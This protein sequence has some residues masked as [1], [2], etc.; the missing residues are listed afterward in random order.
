MESLRL[1][2]KTAIVTGAGRGLGRAHALLLASRGAAVVV[3]DVGV[4]V[5]GTGQAAGPAES[6]V[7]EILAAGG[8]AVAD[9]HSVSEPDAG[10]TL[11]ELARSSFGSVDIIVNNAGIARP[12]PVQHIN[13]ADVIEEMEVHLIGPMS[14]LAAAWSDLKD[15]GTGRV[16]NTASGVGAFGL[17]GAAGYAAAKAA[18]MGFTRTAALE[19]A[20]HGIAVNGVAPIAQTR[21]AGATF[22]DLSAH[23]DPDLVASVVLWLCHPTCPANG[24]TFSAGGGRVARIIVA[25][26]RGIHV[27]GLSAEDVAA[28]APALLADLAAIE[29][30]D[31]MTETELIRAGVE[32]Q[33][34][35]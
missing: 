13:P 23:L 16:V 27:K 25:P 5:A 11:V 30:A 31:A 14:L 34:T 1:D 28:A 10:A 6:V 35:A 22:G 4:S 9:T 17:A 24:E 12:A 20:R 32:G 3:N 8:R 26:T 15:S 29:M 19:G 7:E 2:D 21:M 33:G 18:V